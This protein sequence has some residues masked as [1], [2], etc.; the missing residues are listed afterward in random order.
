[1]SSGNVSFVVNEEL[2]Q[3]VRDLV[4]IRSYSGQEQDV[5]AFIENWFTKQGIVSRQEQAEDGLV[6]VLAEVDGAPGGP[7]LWI[8]GHCDTVG[9]SD[10]WGADP[11]QPSEID[12][13][14]YGRGTMDMKAGLATAMILLRNLHQNREKWAGRVLFASLSDE[15]ARSRGM[16]AH[17]AHLGRVDGA[18]MCEPHFDDVVIGAMGKVNLIVDVEGK[19]AHASLPHEGINAICEAGRLLALIADL[20]RAVSPDFG[21]SSHCV[22]GIEAGDGSYSI[23]VPDHCHFMINWQFPASETVEDGIDLIM[24]LADSLNSPA[25]FRVTARPPAYDSYLIDRDHPFLQA[26]ARSYETILGRAPELRIGKGVSDGNILAGRLDVPTLLFG[27]KGGNMHGA[28]EYLTLSSLE[29]SYAVIARFAADF[30]QDQ[31]Q[32]TS[33]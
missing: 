23:S 3:L 25:Q 30:L 32:G 7:T 24:L 15:E 2:R 20:E 29:A 31:K 17:A 12:G 28:D 8:G 4:S 21:P 26:F 22:I 1:M 19:A 6:N 18:I 11:H 14:L 10:G 5:Q 27:P 9:V 33:R 16:E 13:R